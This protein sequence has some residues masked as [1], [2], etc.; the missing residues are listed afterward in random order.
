MEMASRK[1]L[2]NPSPISTATEFSNTR[3]QGT[4]APACL[5]IVL[6]I[7]IYRQTKWAHLTL[8]LQGA[9]LRKTLR[10]CTVCTRLP[11]LS[12]AN[13][14]TYCTHRPLKFEPVLYNT[15]VA[16]KTGQV[17]KLV[18]VTT[19]CNGQSQVFSRRHC[20][21]VRKGMWG[22]GACLYRNATRNSCSW[23]H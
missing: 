12:T 1:W 21:W 8:M 23:V 17:V 22:G 16:G 18:P 14:C 6:K 15:L 13:S 19:H 3:Q 4:N 11:A 5:G 20:A 7:I 2:W 10:V 9:L